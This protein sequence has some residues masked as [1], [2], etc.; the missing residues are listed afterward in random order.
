MNSDRPRRGIAK[1][2]LRTVAFACTA[3]IAASL[4]AVVLAFQW[5][6]LRAPLEHRLSAGTGRAVTIAELSGWWEQGPRLQ[7][8]DVTV[9]GIEETPLFKAREVSLHVAPWP[10]L[11]GRVELKELG[12]AGAVVDLQRDAD[13]KGNWPGATT[14]EAEQPDR[15]AP[16]PRWQTT[17]IGAV[18]LSDVVLSMRDAVTGLEVRA[19][20][21][22]QPQS[23]EPSAWT[24]RYQLSGH[25]RKTPFAG[26]AYSGTLVTLRDTGIPFPFKGHVDIGR[27]KIDAEGGLSDLLGKMSIDTRLA[28]SGPSLSTLYP[29]IPLA[30][31]TTPPYRL[32]GRLRLHEKV[33]LFDDISGRV[34]RSDMRGYGVFELKQPRPLL[35]ASLDSNRLAL[36]DLGVLIGVPADE[37]ERRKEPRVLPDAKFD[38]SRMNAMNA[39]VVLDARQLVV[40]PEL[41]LEDLSMT[42]ELVDGLLRLRPLKFGF[43]GGEIVSDVALD[44]R[45]APMAADAAFDFRK[46]SFERLFPTID[47][48]RLS[49]GELGA[50]IRLKGRGQSVAEIL[51]SS[52]GT[53]AMAMSGGLISHTVV[54]AAT[55][56]GG[57]LLPLLIRGD[58]PIA[59]R[60]AAVSLVVEQGVGHTQIMVLDTETARVDG[61]GAVDLAAERFELE[62]D[63]K[64]KQPSIL[65]VRAPLHVEGSF[66]QPRVTVS[67]GALLRGG[68]ALA[69][70]VINPLAAL[71]PLIETG[72]GE[73]TNCQQ[74]LTPVEPALKQSKQTSQR[75]PSVGK[76]NARSR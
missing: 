12:L 44:A 6:W 2:R 20:A 66:R 54:A 7:L 61:S 69:L 32:Q 24:T 11:L 33:F 46:V 62:F 28:I 51:G 15:Q 40:S 68:A 43:A 22:S 50:Q 39:D 3:L 37:E 10:L 4:L 25:Y 58:Q 5:N 47:R 56:D 30:L 21:D 42:I 34:G 57:Q 27:T 53:V 38:L 13:G 45:N 74:V 67:S 17:K 14:R 23:A 65:S 75:P 63:A 36:A 52:N 70:G 41:P 73:D 1:P 59:I 76:S 19:R 49:A 8:R 35:T 16:P 26:Q 9:G 29:T 55:L 71:I 64:P 60:C 18:T 31:P 72:P 48:S